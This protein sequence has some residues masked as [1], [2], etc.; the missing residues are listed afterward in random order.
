LFAGG[1]M[2]DIKKRKEELISEL[3]NMRR[4]VAELEGQKG[5]RTRALEASELRYRRLFE[6]AMDGILILDADTGQVMDVNP[7]LIDLVGYSRDEFLGKRLWD[8]GIF[9]DIGKSQALFVGLQDKGYVRYDHLPLQT[10]DGE[11]VD[12]EFVS[13]AYSVDDTKLI[14]CNVRDIGERRLAEKALRESEEKYRT[15]FGES[16]DGVVIT[17]RDGEVLEAN[18]AFLHLFGYEK[19]EIVGRDIRPVYASVTDRDR[20]LQ[21]LESSGF[22]KDYPLNGRRKDGKEID[23]LL[24]SCLRREKDGTILGYHGIIRD[25]TEQKKLQWQLA[26]SQKIEAVSRLAGGIAHDFNNLL[27]V[28]Q[29]FSELLLS[30]RKEADGDYEDLR[31]IHLAAQEGADLVKRILTFSRRAEMNLRPTNLNLEIEHTN[32][33]LERTVPRMIEIK[34]FLSDDLETINA[35]HTQI[36]QLLLNLA[37]NAR[38]AMPEGGTLTI[39]TDNRIL[40]EEYCR[41]HLGAKPGKYAL[42][43]VSDTGG[44]IPKEALEHIFEPFFT[45]KEVG[46]GTGLGLSMVYGIVQ[47]HGGYITVYSEP[48]KGTTFQVYLPVLELEWD[49]KEFRAEEAIASGGSETILLVDDE[50]FLRQLGVRILQRAGYTVVTAGNGIEALEV[51]K[52]QR[53]KIALVILDLIMPQMGGKKCLEEL[54]KMDSKV[55]VLISSGISSGVSDDAEIK[56]S[57]QFRLKGFVKKPFH[58]TDLL[59]AVRQALDSD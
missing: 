28:I 34:T 49:E 9:G 23:C 7:F 54:L 25:V 40:D 10:V 44:G 33:L 19:D 11:V 45:T 42:L 36:E 1:T 17:S 21:A 59:K 47:Q 53:G 18:D 57:T 20:F 52:E 46:K 35:D 15:L 2:E 6:S 32:K 12:V 27:T 37:V 29:G 58:V 22:I 13:N 48:G 41:L 39:Q 24:T 14:Q 43:T 56:Q 8:M 5:S 55:R 31:K 4:R 51:Y 38:D 26:Q 30:D 16:K 50:E 3:A